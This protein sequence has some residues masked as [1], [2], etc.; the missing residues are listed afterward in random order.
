MAARRLYSLELVHF[1]MGPYGE[2]SLKQPTDEQIACIQ[3]VTQ[4]SSNLSVTAYAGCGK[5]TT[6]VDMIAAAGSIP[7]LA[8]AFNRKIATEMQTRLPPNTTCK[9]LNALGHNIWSRTIANRI[10]LDTSK[11]FKLVK[12]AQDRLT[13]KGDK[14][15]FRDNF[16]DILATIRLAKSRGYCPPG[17]FSSR[18]LI[19]RD[20][21]FGGL[22]DE[23]DPAITTQIDDILYRSINQ[24]YTGTIDFD[25]QIYFPTLFGGS[26]PNFPLVCVD[27]AQDLSALNHTMMRK[28]AR[29]RL[30]IVG[31]PNQSIYAFRGAVG[32]GMEKLAEQYSMRPLKLSISF[33]C[34]EAIAAHSRWHVPD[35]KSNIP[36]GSISYHE[37]WNSKNLSQ[38]E[39]A[40]ICRNNAPL[41]KTAMRLLREGR[42]IQL[43]GSDIGPA[44]I[45]ILEKL[46][47]PS[48]RQAEVHRKIDEW[49]KDAE[50]KSRN[51]ASLEDR[52]ECLHVFA[53]TAESLSGALAYAKHLF[54]QE[55]K[56]KLMSGHKAKGL[57][58]D[59]VYHLDAW[60]IP[61]KYANTPEELKQENNVKYVIETRAKKEL[62]YIDT[63]RYMP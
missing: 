29:E 33:R 18:S 25:D 16:S 8:L 39:V 59:T 22:D 1:S 28:L 43:V 37:E 44:L 49:K 10:T 19:S 58:F 54:A 17:Q 14:E 12:D 38:G 57:E 32:D 41:F 5:T 50:R 13:T 4:D 26:F 3:A 36:G 61:S 51:K 15:L 9:T 21:F 46:G 7:I 40:I 31:D 34:P 52:A 20:D 30:I 23:I 11:T 2:T 55:G 62:V 42:S 63:E 53:D 56:V 27:E 60:R 48:I 24:G 6:L 35:F 45:K 47:D